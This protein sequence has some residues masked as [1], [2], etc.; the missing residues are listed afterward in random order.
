MKAR[1]RVK[2]GCKKVEEDET[3]KAW[4]KRH[5]GDMVRG[6]HQQTKEWSLK[7]KVL[8]MV[9]GD[10]LVNVDLK[11]KGPPCSRGVL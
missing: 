10:R 4:P 3:K 7:G 2:G 6:Q 11:D 9:H 1:E 8:E 5:A